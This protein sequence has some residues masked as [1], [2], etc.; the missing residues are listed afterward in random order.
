M[1]SESTRPCLIARTARYQSGGTAA[2]S[3][4]D[5]EGPLP[6][7][8]AS[9]V[10]SSAQPATSAA[11]DGEAVPPSSLS[12]LLSSLSSYVCAELSS[13]RDD[14][15]ALAQCND[16]AAARAARFTRSASSVVGAV[17]TL[18]STAASLSPFLDAIDSLDA[19][20][21]QLEAVVAQL[22]QHTQRMGR[23]KTPPHCTR[24]TSQ[25]AADC[26]PYVA[27][28]LPFSFLS[29][30]VPHAVSI[31]SPAAPFRSVDTSLRSVL[32]HGA[33]TEQQ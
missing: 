33:G 32:W 12:S 5:R 18:Q 31:G 23:K 3:P 6:P 25:R 11:G 30:A 24:S 26:A 14:Y 15:A 8:M 19:S 27:L 10:D 29:R 2:P 1:P 7:L 21:Q 13:S 4:T 28:P 17:R 16:V 9:A 20:L 22:D